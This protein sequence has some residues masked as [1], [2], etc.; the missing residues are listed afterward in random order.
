MTQAI[1]VRSA[2]GG[3]R[4]AF[5]RLVEGTRHA[6]TSIALGILRDVRASEDVAQEVYLQA[7]KDLPSLRSADSF[8][9]WIRQLT[10]NEALTHARSQRRFEKRHA[11]WHDDADVALPAPLETAI[12][13][14]ERL[15]LEEA[16]AAMP[17][18]AR[19]V[20]TLFYRE[21][22]SIR[23]VA[24]LL[25]L[26]EAAV[27]KRLERARDALRADVE[28]RFEAIVSRTATGA[29]F[30]LTVTGAL[31]FTAPSTAAAAAM[32]PHVTKGSIALAILL[33]PF[34]AIPVSVLTGGI[35]LVVLLLRGPIKTAIDD[36]E[37][38]E[39]RR[40]RNIAI[41]L[42]VGF[43]AA[44]FGSLA[45]IRVIG[46]AGAG[47]GFLLSWLAFGFGGGFMLS[48]RL[49]K[50]LARRRAQELTVDPIAFA[51]AERRRRRNSR[52]VLAVVGLA[53]LVVARVV[54]FPYHR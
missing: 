53:F 32:A 4:A 29:A 6:V 17:D 52:I 42:I 5:S 46:D 43:H 9:P 24:H 8:L 41:G 36:Q 14:E 35:A 45:A 27:K 33:S 22:R 28:S 38:R 15:V 25:G 23:Q 40:F 18:D 30:V 20:L 48:H 13:E 47:F 7:W 50:I 49:P 12:S 31:A 3:D 37:R 16:L 21:G 39:L 19:D 10:R 2:A 34:F 11:P 44:L 26:S 1:D 51:E 54:I